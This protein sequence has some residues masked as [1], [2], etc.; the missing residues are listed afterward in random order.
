VP[1]KEPV[2]LPFIF[3]LVF[4]VALALF[5]ALDLFATWGYSSAGVQAFSLGYAAQ[6]FPRSAL[7]SLIPATMTALV[8][9]GL[10]AARKSMSRFLALAI[11]LLA[12]YVV[13]VNGMLLLKGFGSAGRA[14]P[15]TARL[16]VHPRSFLRIGSSVINA[17]RVTDAA[18]NGALVY[19]IDT[20]SGERFAV[21]PSGG[22]TEKNGIFSIQFDGA[23]PAE[24][25]AALP[26]AAGRIFEP[27]PMTAFFLRDMGVLT[28]DFRI[29][30]ASSPAE[31]FIAA[32][33]LLFLSASSMAIMRFTRWPLLNALLLISAV[34]IYFLLYHFLSVTAGPE[35]AKG[36]ADPHI[37]RLFPSIAFIVLGVLFLM[38][39]II[40]IPANR[41]GEGEAL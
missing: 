26:P 14:A 9:S 37:A 19:T 15:V 35:I 2:V 12:S 1:V 16:Y 11:L 40:F 34:R 39:D 5:S 6:Q 20:A 8:I 17:Q 27:D 4:I 7:E 13:L 32:F 24:L 33:A 30:L 22:A 18:V 41:H 31:F 10:R 25:S 3:L 36:L 29:L 23:K 38:I 28:A 21:Y